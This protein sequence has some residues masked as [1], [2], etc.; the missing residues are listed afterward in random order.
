MELSTRPY[1]NA[2][3]A[4]TTATAIAF[5]P[6]AL[7]NPPALHLPM[8]HITVPDI[9]LTSKITSADVKALVANLDA[10]M[11]PRPTRSPTWP[12]YPGRPWS[13]P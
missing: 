6:M 1:L 12:G 10:A 11:G 7:H 5:A 2:G 3:M 13:R 4:L 8:P 9:A